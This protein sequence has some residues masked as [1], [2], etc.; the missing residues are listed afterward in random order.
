MASPHSPYMNPP[1][2]AAAVTPP[3]PPPPPQGPSTYYHHPS[4][5]GPP[6]YHH[7]H[8]YQYH[9]QMPSSPRANGRGGGA[10]APSRG[11][12]A[13]HAHPHAYH[14]H[15]HHNPYSPIQHDPYSP[16]YP[17]YPHHH[18]PYPY[19]QPQTP[20]P[21]YTQ[22]WQ[23]GPHHPPPHHHH[24]HP[25][26]AQPLS[27]M[28]KQLSMVPSQSRGVAS[29]ANPVY[30]DQ[31]P[32]P[33]GSAPDIDSVHARKDTITTTPP[34]KAPSMTPASSSISHSPSSSSSQTPQIQP[35]P[36]AQVQE[37][38]LDASISAFIPSTLTTSTSP[39]T[40][41]VPSSPLHPQPS[42]SATYIQ[43]G[44]ISI[45]SPTSRSSATSI[46]HHPPSSS[47]FRASWA[48]WSRR[49][50]D[51]SHAPGVIISPNARPPRN[52]VQQAIDLRTPP[53][54]PLLSPV[55]DGGGG[56]RENEL[57]THTALPP[58][59]QKSASS[60][61]AG[62]QPTSIEMANIEQQHQLHGSTQ[63]SLIPVS[64]STQ[65]KAD[66]ETTT[67]ADSLGA[68]PR[69][70]LQQQHR[71][72]QQQRQDSNVPSSATSATEHTDALTIPGSPASTNTS[73]SLVGMPGKDAK[74]E[75]G[76][77]RGEVLPVADDVSAE[78]VPSTSSSTPVA[79]TS[80]V[81]TA[82]SSGA[83]PPPQPP[84]K[85]SWASLLKPTEGAAAGTSSSAVTGKGKN[86]LP[87]SNVVGIS[88][89]ASTMAGI[90]SSSSSSGVTGGGGSASSGGK[91]A[92]L[93][94][95][96]SSGV[97]SG[98]GGGYAAA[99]AGASAGGQM[100]IRSR[101]LVNSGNMC[102]ANSVLQV[103]LYCAPFQKLFTELGRLLPASSGVD[104][105][106]KEEAVDER[107]PLVNAIVEF[108]K[109]FVVDSRE[110][111]KKEGV[112]ERRGNGSALLNGYSQ[113]WGKGKEKERDMLDNNADDE[114][115]WVG[116]SFIPTCVYDAMKEKKRFDNMGGG[117]Q[118]DAEEFF[119]FLLDTLEEE[120]LLL[121]ESLTGTKNVS[122]SSGVGE[123]SVGHA[124]Y[125]PV[126][127]KEEA[128]PP[129]EEGWHEVGKKNRMVVTRTIKTAESPVSKIFGGKFRT[130]LKV[131]HTKKDSVIVEDWRSIRLDIQKDQIQTVQD[132][133]SYISH[134]QPV[135]M[136]HPSKPGTIEASQ[137]VHIEALPQVLVL[138]MKR[139]CYDTT[140]GGVVK[141]GKQVQYGPELEI[142]NDL[143]SPHMRKAQP[144]KYKLFAALYH[145]GL[146]ASGGHYT[147]DVLHPNRF[148]SVGAGVVGQKVAKEGWV[149]IDDEFV[150]DVRAEDV[151]GMTAANMW[152]RDESFRCA[153]L[154]FYKRVR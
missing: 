66:Q 146:S 61:A 4:V 120:L 150:S 142:G 30:F 34:R 63:S 9:P 10:S 20:S 76:G 129:E 137:L 7:H 108:V 140:V 96:L 21:T 75:A 147:L 84:V 57:L 44:T 117:Q 65:A 48:I 58:P 17:P 104:G 26:H 50:T 51:P 81:T 99:A 114:D 41:S 11:G 127:E 121:K 36:P 3:P 119:G 45:N 29:P 71:Q 123:K 131:P 72:Q 27:P 59:A 60:T 79:S 90:S 91:T 92:S 144:A 6:Q 112:G 122:S 8:Q 24:P 42:T 2:S 113:A 85:K 135:Q 95:L 83:A 53:H 73:V 80:T 86:A 12:P 101:G 115:F 105:K 136:T 52:I 124:S 118:E 125:T 154:L 69:A 56:G 132:A 49:P 46:S 88:I 106:E 64:S 74:G 134:P 145:H 5:Y 116:E 31:T 87:T 25:H 152:E 18:H 126:E 128:A 67:S 133:L 19:Q 111:G 43:T 151:F 107:T 100:Y 98:S 70:S 89:P 13:A 15:H 1:A 22:S 38:K 93:L 55:D 103:L 139:F 102:F 109:E 14:H 138:H 37:Y 110:W 35:L 39:S 97:G 143:V 77:P 82:P 149:R 40:A 28:P 47:N 148:A 78:Q 141:V 23:G 33:S 32:A 153:Y 130:T 16:K 62:S 54:S 94:A 68:D